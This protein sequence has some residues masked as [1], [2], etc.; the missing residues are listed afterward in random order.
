[1][2]RTIAVAL[3]LG[4][5]LAL[6]CSQETPE[7]AER[8][9]EAGARGLEDAAQKGAAAASAEAAEKAAKAAAAELEARGAEASA[10]AAAED[11]EA[12]VERSAEIMEDSYDDSRAQG[13]GRI[14]AA[15]DAYD[16]VLEE[17]HEQAE[18]AK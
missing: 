12:R 16:A 18:D 15:G 4:L 6:G 1:M 3:A 5:G 7:N 9:A 17:P 13:E 8:Q 10:K 14:E 11:L 2:P